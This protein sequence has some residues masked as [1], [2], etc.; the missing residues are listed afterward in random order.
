M[1]RHGWPLTV[2]AFGA[3]ICLVIIAG[4][5][6]YRYVRAVQV[7]IE[8]TQED[9]VARSRVL[10]RFRIGILSLAVE[11]R[12][13]L[14]NPASPSDAE[15]RG[16]LFELRDSILSALDEAGRLIGP[17]DPV[18]MGHLRSSFEGAPS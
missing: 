10:D 3:L 15:E 12:D 16:R 1:R 11:L 5:V 17:E 18:K 14:L 9:Y 6:L 4:T 8:H 2:L 13:Y 7:Q